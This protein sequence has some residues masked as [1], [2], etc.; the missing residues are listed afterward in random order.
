[1]ANMTLDTEQFMRHGGSER[2]L[3]STSR[4]K[5]VAQQYAASQCPL[6]FKYVT[7]A[8]V[9]YSGGTPG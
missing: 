2:A 8:L 1:M 4:S 3:M 7:R 5:G 9:S 6:M